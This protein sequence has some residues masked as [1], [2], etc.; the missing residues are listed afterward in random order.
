MPPV[1]VTNKRFEDTLPH[2][3]G[4]HRTVILTYDAKMV[5]QKFQPQID[6]GCRIFECVGKQ[7]AYNT[8]HR[9]GIGPGL[10]RFLRQEKPVIDSPLSR[11]GIKTVKYPLD[12]IGQVTLLAL[13]RVSLLLNTSEIHQL[14]HQLVQSFRIA[15]KDGNILLHRVVGNF[16]HL[17]PDRLRRC[18][19]QGQW[20]PDFVSQIRDKIQFR[21]IQILGIFGLDLVFL[22]LYSF[23][24]PPADKHSRD[25]VN[26]PCQ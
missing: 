17:G 10:N 12:N 18:G 9:I 2:I 25:E 11:T 8:V 24:R 19:N 14:Q 3:Q 15:G 1:F 5:I 4:N 22:V 13:D 6:E 21:D 23:F 7:V 16:G 20:R 26:S